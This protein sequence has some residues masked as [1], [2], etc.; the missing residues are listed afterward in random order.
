MIIFLCYSLILLFTTPIWNPLLS[1]LRFS[2]ENMES[3]GA[4]FLGKNYLRLQA[5]FLSENMESDTSLFLIWQ[6]R[7]GMGGSGCGTRMQ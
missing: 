7:C 1:S 5:L 4:V 2:R 3:Y 6:E